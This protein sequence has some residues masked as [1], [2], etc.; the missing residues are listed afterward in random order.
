MRV[1][2][3][4]TRTVV[5]RGDPPTAWRVICATCEAGG[6]VLHRTKEAAERAAVRDSNKPCSSCGAS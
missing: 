4:G 2:T 6:T 5:E 1:F 3:C